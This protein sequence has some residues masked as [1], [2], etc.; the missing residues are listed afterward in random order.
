MNEL[1]P[2]LVDRHNAWE[3]GRVRGA[4]QSQ[5]R[6]PQPPPISY[7]GDRRH[8]SQGPSR[9][10][11]MTEQQG[12]GKRVWY[13][14]LSA[15]RRRYEELTISHAQ[16]KSR[17]PRSRAEQEGIL[18]RQR[19]AED[20]SRIMQKAAL[21]GNNPL[22][23]PLP[24]PGAVT[25]QRSASHASSNGTTSSLE[26][27]PLLPLESPNRKY[28]GDSTDAETDYHDAD[29]LYKRVADI[30]IGRDESAPFGG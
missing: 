6:S 8:R 11:S 20:E 26:P 19:E 30:S 2:A 22:Q 13:P 23:P 25:P 18:Q 28:D 14:D 21:Y 24:N 1:K 3:E 7:D 12:E 9:K 29:R 16:P 5:T 4:S 15:D 17:S 27:L 10:P